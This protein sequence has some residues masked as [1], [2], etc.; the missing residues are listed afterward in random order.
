ME[1]V[2]GA[3]A[4]TSRRL[5]AE[6]MCRRLV[7]VLIGIYLLEAVEKSRTVAEMILPAGETLL[8]ADA[9]QILLVCL[10]WAL[11]PQKV[12]ALHPVAQEMARIRPVCRE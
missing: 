6:R 7:E 8:Q 3:A 1:A 2:A 12:Y 10:G 9:D 11:N 5:A 4:E